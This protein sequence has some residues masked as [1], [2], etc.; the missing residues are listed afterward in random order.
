MIVD[1]LEVMESIIADNK[2][3]S[4][5]GW[6]V[7]EMTQSDKGRLSTTGAFVNG[8]WYIKKIFSPSRD[9]WNIPTKYVG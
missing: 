7:I 4:W 1:K 5:D 3:L 8:A 9:G 6:D 2:K